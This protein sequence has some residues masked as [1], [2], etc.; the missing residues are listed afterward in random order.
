MGYPVSGATPGSHG[1]VPVRWPVRSGA[2][3]PLAEKFSVRQESAPSLESALLRNP[4]VT[5]TST[6]QYGAEP[7][8]L[9]G[10]CGKTQLAVFYAESHWQ[11]RALDLLLWVD[12]SSRASILCGYAEA[13]AAIGA[14]SS[15]TGAEPIAAGFVDWLS[16]TR[17]RWLV[18]LDGLADARDVE[19]LWPEGRAGQVVVTA[20]NPE[21]LGGRSLCLEIGAYSRRDAMSYMVGRLTSDPEQRRGAIELIEDLGL[22][23]MALA[24]ASAVI[25]NS[26][27]TCSDYRDHLA[28]RQRQRADATGVKPH[29]AAI[30]WVLA[31]EQADALLPGGSPQSCLAFTALLHGLGVPVGVFATAM[32][33]DYMAGARA[34][35]DR[36]PEPAFS[37]LQALE[38]VGLVVIDRVSQPP[39]VQMNTAVQAAIQ[40]ATPA[41]LANRA[42]VA[43][44]SA[45]LE[46]WPEGDQRTR[47]AQLLRSSAVC[48]QRLAPD[49]LW[50]NGCP[51]VLTRAGQSF[52]SAGLSGPAVEYWSELTAAS[53]Q[54]L[55][56]GHPD[57]MA[58]VER[59]AR[60]YV[61]SGQADEAIA[62]YQRISAEWSTAFGS[63]DSR[64]LKARVNLGRVLVTAGLTEDAVGVLSVAVK[65]CER[66]LGPDDPESQRAR[67]ELATALRATG[68]LD[69]AIRLYQRVLGEQERLAG[70]RSPVTMATRQNL[71]AAYLDAGRL[72]EALAQ[73]KRT[74][75]DSERT[76]GAEHP[77][78]LRVRSALATAYHR[79][80]RMAMSVQLQEQVY[81][82]SERLLGADNADT[83]AVAV[84]LAG[85][86]YAV[87]RLTDAAKL[88]ADALPRAESTLGPAHP[89]TQSARDG[90]TA[91]TGQPSG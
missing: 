13:A 6:G 73:Y 15:L 90:L 50:A 7:A 55:G 66:V 2:V 58:L 32:A 80:G 87:G 68:Q 53:D 39:T 54:I 34:G 21:S 77:D 82:T 17:R 51:A 42:A 63:D 41:S 71:A 45:L 64:T 89:L 52:D 12:A 28:A 40:A 78:T 88:Y 4:A 24:Q 84:S 70:P 10:A 46:V 23:P 31:A 43:A 48:L 60:A 36:P 11:A 26:W 76:L 20:R 16:G 74:L 65:D 59:L 81:R 5:L 61:A 22:Q 67:E 62:W 38:R 8:D 1:A 83:L 47:H 85:G 49:G 56:P 29:A 69:E 44:A 27:L 33:C 30:T 57:S 91:I 19:G 3:P 75:S 79:A 72:K 25:A 14:A 86:Y 35:I 9:A 18:V 37:A